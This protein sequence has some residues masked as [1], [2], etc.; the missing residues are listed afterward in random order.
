MSE[1]RGASPGLPEHHSW[2]AGRE[3]VGRAGR[4]EVAS[5]ADGR[6]FAEATLLDAEQ[7]GE[8]LD[9]ATEAFPSWSRAGFRERGRALQ[10]LREALVDEAEEIARAASRS[11]HGETLT[12]AD[13]ADAGRLLPDRLRDGDTILVKGSRVVGLEKL[14]KCIGERFSPRRCETA[15]V[16]SE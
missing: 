12:F 2:I 14:V 15:R 5:P 13:V 1:S 8:A 9:A 7:I 6:P 11:G 3:V 10:R 4:R 16:C